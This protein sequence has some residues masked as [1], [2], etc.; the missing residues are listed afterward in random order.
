[1]KTLTAVLPPLLVLDPL[2]KNWLLEDIGRG[3]RTTQSLLSDG[4][5]TKDATWIAKESGVVAGSMG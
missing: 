4:A 2:L 3:D 5:R 1:M